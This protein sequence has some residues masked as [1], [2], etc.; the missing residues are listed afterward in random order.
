MLQ[1]FLA[2]G[3]SGAASPRQGKETHLKM[4]LSTVDSGKL[5]ILGSLF[6]SC[7]QIS[8]KRLLG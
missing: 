5:V 6:Q 8:E 4:V 1:K 2:K 7:L 3:A